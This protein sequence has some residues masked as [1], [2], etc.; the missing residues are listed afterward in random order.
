MHEEIVAIEEE[1]FQQLGIPYQVSIPAVET[2]ST[3]L[4]Q[5]R[6]RSLMPGRNT[7]GEVTSASNCT[8]FQSRRLGIRCRLPEKKG[9]Q[10]VHTLNGTCVAISR[11]LIAVLENYQ[12][13]DGGIENPEILRPWWG[14][15]TL[16]P[17]EP[18]LSETDFSPDPVGQAPASNQVA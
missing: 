13:A 17:G 3:S 4:S 16:H 10:H 8:D 14:N 11:A 1:V 6:F 15:I 9:T 7:F 12:L 18:P 5:V 2:W